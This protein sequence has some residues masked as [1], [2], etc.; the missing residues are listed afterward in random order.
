MIPR[1]P[2]KVQK[3][4]VA[5]WI[6]QKSM[7][8]TETVLL[9]LFGYSQ[10]RMW[11][12]EMTIRLKMTALISSYCG[13]LNLLFALLKILFSSF[14]SDVSWS[15]RG[16]VSRNSE[17]RTECLCNHFTSFAVLTEVRQVSVSTDMYYLK[18][19][20]INEFFFNY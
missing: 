5:F 3:D 9:N 7:N 19:E 20:V 18:H 11:E 13:Y 17:E 4:L 15:T 16:C 1:S 8:P 6:S 14:R 2:L 10:S 12:I